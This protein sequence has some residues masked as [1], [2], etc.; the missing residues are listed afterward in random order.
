MNAE[1]AS[2]R[3]IETVRK[4]Y[5]SERDRDLEVWRTF[6]HADGRQT[7]PTLGPDAT[8]S[9]ID[10]LTEVTREKFVTRPPYGIAD[11]VEGF[12]DPARVFAALDLSFPGA[13]VI[14]IWCIFT[15]DGN[16]L[17]LEVEEIFDRGD[18][19]ATEGAE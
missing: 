6:W 5:Q 12:A 8:V 16:G 18:A 17:V 4:F 15:F 1:Q 7:F 10:A 19:P 13:P 11:H 14:T 3:N 9:G 2:A